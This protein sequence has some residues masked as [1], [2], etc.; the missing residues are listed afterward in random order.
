M[1]ILCDYFI[2][3]TGWMYSIR[4]IERTYSSNSIKEKIHKVDSRSIVGDFFIQ[5]FKILSIAK[6]EIWWYLH[7]SKHYSHISSSKQNYDFFNIILKILKTHPPQSIVSSNN[8]YS[9]ISRTSICKYPIK[10]CLEFWRCISR[11]SSIYH[12]YKISRTSKFLLELWW[13]WVL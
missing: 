6:S 7:S 13:I 1:N 11:N 4:K 10:S 9:N 12:F 3:S 8:K 5:G 2:S